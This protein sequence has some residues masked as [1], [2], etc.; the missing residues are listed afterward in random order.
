ML[1]IDGLASGLDTTSIIEGLLSI[2]QT[3]IDRFN[4]QKQKV[5]EQ[6]TAFRSIEARLLTLKS[7]LSELTRPGGNAFLRKQLVS[8]DPARIEAS[9]S[10]EAGEGIYSVRVD[11]LARNHQVASQVYNSADEAIA[12]GTL[13]IGVGG[14]Q[15][16]EIVVSQSNASLE[17][18]ATSINS[19][20]EGVT[21]TVIRQGGG[22]RLLLAAD[23]TGVSNQITFSFA[24]DEATPANPIIAIDLDNPVQA[25]ENATIQLGTGSGAAFIRERDESGRR[26]FSWHYDESAPGNGGR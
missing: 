24:P 1:N 15:A 18:I 20:V 19:T 6:K 8:S 21:A 17:G 4:A 9:V 23:E 10:N 13:A 2:Q 16:T 14:R 5:V 3:Q 25:A 26:S 7:T 22:H 12:T 11:Q